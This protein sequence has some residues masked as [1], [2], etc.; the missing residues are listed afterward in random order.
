MRHLVFALCG[1]FLR[2]LIT[3]KIFALLKEAFLYQLIASDILV[4]CTTTSGYCTL[5][6]LMILIAIQVRDMRQVQ[7]PLWIL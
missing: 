1:P 5:S 6:F 7:C 3:R 4:N 2:A